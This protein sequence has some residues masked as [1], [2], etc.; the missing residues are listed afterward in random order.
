V[1]V[2]VVTLV[3][4]RPG[5]PFRERHWRY[6]REHLETLGY[7]IFT[8]DSVGAWARAEACNNAAKAA[9]DWDVALITDA[10][11]ILESTAVR[12][13]V[14][15][16]S[17]SGGAARPHD[18][19]YMLSLGASKM[20]M[21]NGTVSEKYLRWTAPGGGALVIARSTWE[22]VGGYDERFVGWGYED[23]AMNISLVGQWRII[24]GVSYHLFHAPASIRTPT[25]KANKALL[26]EHRAEHLEAIR[27]ASERAGFDLNTV[28]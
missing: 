16:V 15:V 18:R 13:A 14:N 7:P 3:P 10:D 27:A 23:S 6:V 11:T 21:S 2:R 9:G 28:L 25:A 8:G 26:E 1:G 20:L 19:R 12:R 17:K 22:E 5:E 4:W 24:P